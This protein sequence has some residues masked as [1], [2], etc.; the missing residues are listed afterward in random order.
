[1]ERPGRLPLAWLLA[2]R[3]GA[4]PEGQAPSELA[5]MNH[6][7]QLLALGLLGGLDELVASEAKC[8]PAIYDYLNR[9]HEA[10]SVALLLGLAATRRGSGC[11]AVARLLQLHVPALHPP[12]A[13]ELE[14]LREMPLVQGAALVGLGLLHCSSAQRRLAEVFL[15]E[16]TR[17]P[18][19]D[20]RRFQAEGHALSAGFALGFLALARGHAP[21][22]ADLRLEDRLRA[23][24]EGLPSAAV[25]IAPQTPHHQP[26]PP[27][28]RG[29]A[30]GGGGGTVMERRGRANPEASGPGA[31]VA[32]A[33]MFL[34]SGR[35]S[36]ARPL[37]P[38]AS[39][40]L[41]RQARPDLLLLRAL[42]RAL[43]LSAD[44]IRP[45]T[46]WLLDQL[47]TYLR[48][49][50]RRRRR[51]STLGESSREGNEE[52]DKEEEAEAEEEEEEEEAVAGDEVAAELEEARAA[53]EAGACLA[54]GLRFASSQRAD[55]FAL[56][57]ERV[58]AFE[59]RRRAQTRPER[60]LAAERCVDAA[61]LGLALVAAGSG[62]LRVLRRI[63]RLRKRLDA[64]AGYGHHVAMHLAL[65]LLFLGRGRLA[66]GQDPEAT[67]AL[68]AAVY[69]L[70][71]AW[72]GDHS[73][74]LQALRHLYVL[75]ARPRCLV[76]RDIDTGVAVPVPL[77]LELLRAGAGP[78]LRLVAPCLLPEAPPALGLNKNIA[79]E[80]LVRVSSPR[81]WAREL[82]ARR[83]EELARWTLWVRRRAG[84]PSY[85][86]DPRGSTALLV[87]TSPR[88]DPS[89]LLL[90]LMR[91]SPPAGSGDGGG[92]EGDD[93]QGGGWRALVAAARELV[94]SERVALLPA[95][96]AMIAVA[97]RP[98]LARPHELE[99]ARACLAW[100][101]HNPGAL[102]P[103][104][105]ASLERRLE[106]RLEGL[107]SRERALLRRCLLDPGQSA[108]LPSPF[109]EFAALLG[110][111]P[112]DV[113][114]RLSA[115]LAG[116]SPPGS[117][118]AVAA[119]A[120]VGPPPPPPRR[121]LL[122][123]LLSLSFAL[124]PRYAHILSDII[125]TPT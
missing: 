68:L 56:L 117:A 10:T 50:R 27:R 70:F 40:Q 15:G 112:P 13:P 37:E 81:Y 46:A 7:G 9:G 29:H 52:E 79:P 16:I 83:P 82:R 94:A 2:Q 18:A 88:H 54:L 3:P 64:S 110:G 44:H 109:L 75:A 47:P 6:A 24:I 65:G 30:N 92:G 80:W 42:C 98:E 1:V 78:L 125:L 61:L 114:S 77:E 25:A 43:V 28:G 14:P 51:A 102:T 11:T 33:L 105:L 89:S 49:R 45:D 35:A 63:R 31:M 41:M 119:S 34:G 84:F 4:G 55:A 74:H 39:P 118:T 73:A 116:M 72:S 86:E 90:P 108:P 121:A 67:A 8:S 21:A 20:E 122:P 100:A 91:L 58:D 96:V 53:I 97:A 113:S 111:L 85:K 66:L 87:S 17:R 103:T 106:A 60:Q 62:D 71:P 48:R 22:L 32:L 36:A 104:L 107:I 26:Q 123:P 76:A 93:G 19:P 120:V 69:P 99:Q 115:L 12:S 101:Q 124:P 57:L 5:L 95:Y 23:C 59:R 38:P